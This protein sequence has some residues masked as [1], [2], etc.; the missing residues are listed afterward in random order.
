MHHASQTVRGFGILEFLITLAILALILVKAVPA[1]NVV[2][3]HQRYQ[4]QLDHLINALEFANTASKFSGRW[5]IVCPRR[6]DDHCDNKHNWSNGWL[7][8]IDRNQN[9]Q[10]DA[11]D[12]IRRRYRPQWPIAVLKKSGLPSVIY[13][14]KGLYFSASTFLICNRK[15][16]RKQTTM[17][18]AITGHLRRQSSND[19]PC[20]D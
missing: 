2:I 12:S 5:M 11:Q 20:L 13:T 18:L 8:V 14:P 9:H 19:L 3:H 17:K 15:D 16:P 4:M 1:F 7:V 6:D 10:F